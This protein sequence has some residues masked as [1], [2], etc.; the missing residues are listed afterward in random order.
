MYIYKAHRTNR[1]KK[2]VGNKTEIKQRHSQIKKAVFVILYSLLPVFV[3]S[4]QPLYTPCRLEA[5]LK[6]SQILVFLRR[7]P[8]ST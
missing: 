7:S 2:N 5:R 4:L 3:F 1:T 8:G 6:K